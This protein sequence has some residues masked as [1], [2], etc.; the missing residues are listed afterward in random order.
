MYQEQQPQRTWRDILRSMNAK[1]KQRLVKE[2][3]IQSK[4]LDRWIHGQ[5]DL[6]RLNRLRQLLT[7]LPAEMRTSFIESVQQDPHFAKYA[8][9]IPLLT[10]RA[11]IP[12]AYYARIIRTY[13]STPGSVRFTSVCQLALLQAVG[14]LDA[15]GRGLSM[16]ILMCTP[17]SQGNKV[18]TLSQR[19][20]LGTFPGST[21]VEQ[22]SFFLGAESVAGQ[23][24]ITRGQFVIQDIYNS[25]DS[26]IYSIHQEKHN[27]SVAAIPLQ[28]DGRIAGC[29]LILS[30][31]PNFFTPARLAIIQQ[32]CDLV[33]IAINEDEFYDPQQIALD[34]MPPFSVQQEYLPQFREHVSTIIR[35]SS[36]DGHPRNWLEV[37]REVRQRIEA[38][39]LEREAQERQRKGKQ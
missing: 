21:V 37:E 1:E 29:V 3:G 9:E 15:E 7:I 25:G 22:K 39:L 17:P 11:E 12:S 31:Q 16:V 5:T 19:F 27:R 38:E 18:R 13:V 8:N 14:L 32:Y 20:S 35:R 24:V 4:T 26:G 34:F 23:A 30:A 33:A 10:P 28:T 2:M 36:I 6:P